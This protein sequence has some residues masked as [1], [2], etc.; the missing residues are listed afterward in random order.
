VRLC[1]FI[2]EKPAQLIVKKLF[3]W[4][5]WLQVLVT[6]EILENTNS[7]SKRVY[8]ILI[9]EGGIILTCN[10]EVLCSQLEW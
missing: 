2:E 8:R 5:N 9:Y 3:C 4:S 7:F 10:D 6:G 1:S